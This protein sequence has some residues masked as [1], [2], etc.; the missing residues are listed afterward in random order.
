ME[1]YDFYENLEIYYNQY[2]PKEEINRQKYL[3]NKK[4]IQSSTLMVMGFLIYYF[5]NK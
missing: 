1:V 5:Y 3:E 4:Y 2:K